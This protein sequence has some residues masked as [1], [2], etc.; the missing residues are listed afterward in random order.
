MT[1]SA[2]DTQH[3]SNIIEKSGVSM[4]IARFIST[5]I[6]ENKSMLVYCTCKRPF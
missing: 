6:K 5:E 4:F 1:P 3:L 2:D